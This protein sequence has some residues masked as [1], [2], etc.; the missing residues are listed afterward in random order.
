MEESKN[1]KLIVAKETVFD[2]IIGFFKK[3]FSKKNKE[4]VNNN[5]NIIDDTKEKGSRNT[6][7]S[8]G[9]KVKQNNENEDRLTNLQKLIAEDMITEDELPEEDIKELHKLYDS[10]ILELKRSIDE[11]REKILKIRMNISE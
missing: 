10:Q 1:N 7:F 3:I 2:K 6:T 5:P 9:I 4:E 8:E 11:Y